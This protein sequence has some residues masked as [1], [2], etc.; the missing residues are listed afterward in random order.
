MDNAAAGLR[1][2]RAPPNQVTYRRA[3]PL[4]TAGKFNTF[5][6]SLRLAPFF[7]WRVGFHSAPAWGEHPISIV[8]KVCHHRFITPKGK[9]LKF[10]NSKDSTRPSED[11]SLTVAGVE[12]KIHHNQD[13]NA[14]TDKSPATNLPPHRPPSETRRDDQSMPS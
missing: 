8:S 3:N 9:G 13:A 1:H 11:A 10:M 4:A 7:H 14:S 12:G 6:D 2:S 5:P